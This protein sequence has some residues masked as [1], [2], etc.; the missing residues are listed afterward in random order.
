MLNTL[1]EQRHVHVHGAALQDAAVLQRRLI[2]VEQVTVECDSLVSEGDRLQLEK[3]LLQ[4]KNSCAWSELD[5]MRAR[6]NNSDH[7]FASL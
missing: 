3:A 4:L 1:T 6:R 5:R 7:H 2:L